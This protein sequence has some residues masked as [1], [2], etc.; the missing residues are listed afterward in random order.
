LDHIR[1]RSC[2]A[3]Q[4]IPTQLGDVLILRTERSYTIHVVGAISRDGQ[5]DFENQQMPLKYETERAAAV[6]AKAL[7]AA[8]P[9][10]FF[11]SLDTDEWSVISN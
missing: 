5:Q 9:R 4:P 8:G 6:A 1:F 3:R 2:S 11:R 7:V 10:I